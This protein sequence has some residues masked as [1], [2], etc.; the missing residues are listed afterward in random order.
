LQAH[1]VKLGEFQE[2]PAEIT[3]A[4]QASLNGRTSVSKVHAD[5]G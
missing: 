2:K 1:A 5:L 3:A 4:Y